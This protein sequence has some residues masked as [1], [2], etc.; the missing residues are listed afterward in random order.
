Q[1]HTHMLIC[2]TFLSLSPRCLVYSIYQPTQQV[3]VSGGGNAVSEIKDVTWTTAS[4]AQHIVHAGL[5]NRPRGQQQRWIQIA[6]YAAVIGETA[7]R[8]THKPHRCGI[9]WSTITGIQKPCPP[10]RG[11]NSEYSFL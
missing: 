2:H 7:T 8:L 10:R 6:L 1:H 3:R 11:K 4:T 9:R 5:N